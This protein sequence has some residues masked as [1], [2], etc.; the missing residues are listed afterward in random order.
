MPLLNQNKLV[1]CVASVHTS[2]AA[3]PLDICKTPT[4]GGPVPMPYPNVAVSSTMG[5]GYTTK[6]LCMGTPMWTKKGKSALSNGDQPG[7]ALGVVSNKIMG[8][9]AILMASNDVEAE[10]SGVART[11]DSSNGNI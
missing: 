8:M 3:G 5:P 10:G 9:V 6:T 7:V 11:G 1:A 2:V 4:P